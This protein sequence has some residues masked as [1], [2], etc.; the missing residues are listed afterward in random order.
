MA[1]SGRQS[2]DCMA[3]LRCSLVAPRT[4]IFVLMNV[5]WDTRMPY[6]GRYNRSGSGIP[7]QSNASHFGG[8]F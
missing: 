3:S 7:T 2:E 8:Y 6:D 4:A 5:P 1:H